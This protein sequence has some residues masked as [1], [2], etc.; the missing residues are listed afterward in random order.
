[1]SKCENITKPF[2]S[3]C[4]I[5]C[6]KAKVKNPKIKIMVLSPFINEI[7][8]PHFM[9]SDGKYDY[10]F[11]VD[12]HVPC[13]LWFKGCIRRRTLGFNKKWKQAAI[14]AHYRRKLRE[15]IKRCE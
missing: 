4:L 14:R 10:D 9:W 8:C 11:G 1:M 6:I 3:N 5:E 13:V 2:Y 12:G 15:K 7:F